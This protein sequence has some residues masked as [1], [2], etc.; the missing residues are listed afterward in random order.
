MIS[1]YFLEAHDDTRSWLDL[2]E[3]FEA[4]DNVHTH[5]VCTNL[6]EQLDVFIS[7]SIDLA[8]VDSQLA[9]VSIPQC[10]EHSCLLLSSE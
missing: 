5:A 8:D 6:S 4:F 3:I 1:A 2:R 10:L 9:W 7:V